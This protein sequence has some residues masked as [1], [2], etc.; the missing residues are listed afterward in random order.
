MGK[1]I[2]LVKSL[3]DQSPFGKVVN[4][5]IIVVGVVAVLFTIWF[6]FIKPGQDR[7]AA[8]QSNVDAQIAAGQRT[9][10][11]EAIDSIGE[12]LGLNTK[13]DTNVKDSSD[14]IR[15]APTASTPVSRDLNCAG[16]RAQCLSV[17]YRDTPRCRSVLQACPG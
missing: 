6:I 13:V 5:T 8:I 16:L 2:A 12:A 3:W 10:A 1:P 4:I 15:Q 11:E 7:R 17:S 14:A 9:S